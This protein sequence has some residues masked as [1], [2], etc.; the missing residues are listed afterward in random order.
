[1]R[2]FEGPKKPDKP[3]IISVLIGIHNQIIEG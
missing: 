2:E 1:M 3:A